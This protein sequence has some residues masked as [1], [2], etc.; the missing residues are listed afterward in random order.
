MIDVKD[1]NYLNDGKR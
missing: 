1:A